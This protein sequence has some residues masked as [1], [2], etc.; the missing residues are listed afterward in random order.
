M[1]FRGITVDVPVSDLERARSFYEWWHGRPADLTPN[2][3]V[4]E[5]ILHSTPQVAFRVVLD[6]DRAGTARV[7]VGVDDLEQERD[8]LTG[9]RV[10]VAAEITRIPGV[11][12][13]FQ[14]EDDDGNKLVYWE[15]LLQ[16]R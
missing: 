9:T 2:P 13:L 7:G 3:D 10:R 1:S 5:W 16:S 15:D 12:A 14:L 6:P 8:R 4:V 11:I